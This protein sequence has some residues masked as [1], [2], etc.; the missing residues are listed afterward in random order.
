MKRI[1]I[2]FGDSGQSSEEVVRITLPAS[3]PEQKPMEQQLVSARIANP[4]DAGAAPSFG[5][6]NR[7]PDQAPTEMDPIPATVDRDNAFN[8]GAAPQSG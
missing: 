5:T 6:A 1:I 7:E 4:L 3:E 2:E 8:A